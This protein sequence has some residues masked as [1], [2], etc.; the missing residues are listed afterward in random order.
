MSETA[1]SRKLILNLVLGAESNFYVREISEVSHIHTAW[2][3]SI[4][5]SKPLR[6]AALIRQ[7]TVT[8]W[9]GLH[10]EETTNETQN[11]KETVV[12]QL[13]WINVPHLEESVS[14]ETWSRAQTNQNIRERIVTGSQLKSIPSGFSG[15][16]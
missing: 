16:V 11:R 1:L 8:L 13:A 7:E 4:I 12:R 6:W 10:R 15:L 3:V 2:N 5:P 14:S 9:A